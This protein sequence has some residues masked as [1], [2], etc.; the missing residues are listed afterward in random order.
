VIKGIDISHHQPVKSI[1]WK[2]IKAAGYEFAF[3]RATY[4]ISVDET[5]EPHVKGALDGG[6]R[7][8]PYGFFR[9]QQD[10]A[11]QVAAYEKALSSVPR[12]SLLIPALDF[13]PSDKYDGA[14]SGS[15]AAKNGK[16]L[17][18]WSLA[19]YGKALVY[20]S[21]TYWNLAGRPPWLVSPDVLWWVCHWDTESPDL[22]PGVD[23]TIW[24]TGKAKTT[25]ATGEV[26]QNVIRS[27]WAL[28]SLLVS[29]APEPVPVPAP[30]PVVLSEAEAMAG[31]VKGLRLVADGIEAMAARKK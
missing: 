11:A 19:T 31:I 26:D 15:L 2:K 17:V 16:P 25:G 8:G 20:S 6:L 28:D 30:V 22:P 14:V 7:V 24:Q 3:V 1:D 21:L 12:S 5:F 18:D 4:G 13:E 27:R 9:Q 10:G 23:W 29:P